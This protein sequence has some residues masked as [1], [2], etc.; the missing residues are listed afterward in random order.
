MRAVKWGNILDPTKSILITGASSGIGEALAL[1]YA[2]NSS[3]LALCGRDRQRLDEV[4]EQCRALGS[5]VTAAVIDVRDAS[6]TA[7]WIEEMDRQ[8]PLDL[9][10][11]NAGISGGGG[12]NVTE[13]AKAIF[14]VNL[15][16]V[17]NTVHPA[18]A[19][20][21]ERGRG[22]IAIMSSLA[23]FVGMPGA[24]A[25]GA[26]K[27]AVRSYG[28]ALRGRCSADGIA[29]SVACPGFVVSR[30][31]DKNRFRM[32]FLMSAAKAAAIIDKG[33]RRNKAR[34]AFPWPLYWAVRVV[35][36]LPVV[37]SDRIFRRLPE[38]D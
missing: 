2:G 35:Q 24:P 1:R 28:E 5:Q 19:R 23:G 7:A 18:L 27:A 4:A 32:P 16:G 11:A 29:V 22:Q 36:A 34:I 10:I 37:V 21:V 26:S 9:V 15:G 20:M 30:I 6:S 3:T 31:T 17:L 25:Y 12:T 8:A 38:K 14:D 33:L 13:S